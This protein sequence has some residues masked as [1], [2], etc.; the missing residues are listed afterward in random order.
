MV[1]GQLLKRSR[2]SGVGACVCGGCHVPHTCA[3]RGSPL[4]NMLGRILPVCDVN[5][6]PCARHPDSI[7]RFLLREPPNPQPPKAPKPYRIQ[8]TWSRASFHC[9]PAPR[10]RS[11]FRL[12]NMA[13]R[14]RSHI[15][16]GMWSPPAE[17]NTGRKLCLPKDDC[18]DDRHRQ[19]PV[20]R[21]NTAATPNDLKLHRRLP[22]KPLGV[23]RR[24]MFFMR[25]LSSII[26]SSLLCPS[27]Y[28]FDVEE[29]AGRGRGGVTRVTVPPPAPHPPM[30]TT[31][32][33]K[34]SIGALARRSGESF[35]VR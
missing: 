6:D 18:N 17:A 30:A 13:I 26:S 16:L 2:C 11:P 20:S 23:C 22:C 4:I 31:T 5:T 25:W 1:T 24:L 14:N 7:L 19:M 32:L 35:K 9:L 29:S 15:W 28:R 21:R 33:G 27:L 10:R 3:Y 12:K 8:L 34:I